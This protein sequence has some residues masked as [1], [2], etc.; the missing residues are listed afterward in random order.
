VDMSEL[1]NLQFSGP[2]PW[3]E[4]QPAIALRYAE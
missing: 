3:R 2:K 4:L 1:A